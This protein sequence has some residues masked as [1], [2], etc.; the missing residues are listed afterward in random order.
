MDTARWVRV[1]H[2]TDP[3]GHAAGT[4]ATRAAL[5][6]GRDPKLLVVFAAYEYDLT[7][8]IAGVS[9]V[10]AGAGGAGRVPV[11]GCTT[12]GEIGPGPALGDGVVVVGFGGA[13]EV[14]TACATG[15][16]D[17]S[18]R[19]GEE[20]GTA[21][22]PL[23]ATEHRAAIVLTDSLAGDQQEMIR[24]A[25]G[26]LGA[27]VP[28]I[29]GGA[30]DNMRMVTSRQFYGDRVVQDAVVAACVGSPGPLGI[31]VQHGWSRCSDPMVVTDSTGN[32]VL[33][34]DDRPALDLYLERFH[35]PPG[36]DADPAKFFEFA[37][38][39]PLAISRR[40]DDAVRHI[41]GADPRSRSLMCAG[42]V[43]KG[44]TAWLMSGTV[45]SSLAATGDACAEAIGQLGDTPPRALLVFDCAGRRALLG[46]AG[47]EAERATIERL[48][49]DV[50]LAGFYTFGEI[51]RTR[52]VNGFHNQTIVAVAV[53]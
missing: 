15:L 23:P 3:S 7:A 20:I 37:L 2:S 14:R 44:A 22:L 27:T 6:G 53:S 5:D 49:G 4:A 31:A 39:R 12:A 36:L 52:G 41:L 43:P 35:A 10:A 13:F 18:R 33:A 30:G 48:A 42:G 9:T 34:F 28:L 40:G 11:I 8:L 1:G 24:G 19:V 51:A 45:E 50:P 46:D 16:A 47:M 26:V 25:Y 32:R 17:D 21:L 38:T 29:G